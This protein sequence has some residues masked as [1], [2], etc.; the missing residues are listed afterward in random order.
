MKMN[1]LGWVSLCLGLLVSA[2]QA[3]EMP[4]VTVKSFTLTGEIQGENITFAMDMTVDAA[5]GGSR[6]TLASGSIA[7]LDGQLPGGVELKRDGASYEAVFERRG[8]LASLFGGGDE[9]RLTA[10]FAALAAESNDWRSTSFDVP[11]A[12]VRQ[13]VIVCDREDLAVQFPGAVQVDRRKN[14]AGKTE[15]VAYLTPGSM[16]AVHWKPQVRKLQGELAVTCD[17]CAVASASVGA[18]KLDTVFTYRVVQGQLERLSLAVPDQ[19]NVTQVSGEDIREWRLDPRPGGGRV[20]SVALSRPQAK[21]YVLRVEGER[22]LAA[23][24]CKF[25]LPVVVP[26]GVIRAGGFLLLGTDSAVRLI[27]AK[28]AGLSQIDPSA[29]PKSASPEAQR[30]IVPQ[31]AA[32]AYQYAHLPFQMEL[33]AEDIVTSLSSEER[34]T[35]SCEDNGL[36]LDAVVDVEIRDAPTRELVLETDP[37]WAVAQVQ[38]SNVSDYDVRDQA[39]KREI[40]VYFQDAAIGHVLV[41]VRLERTLGA[42]LATFTAPKLALRDAKAERG[43]LVLR[44]EKG[45]RLKEGKAAELREIHTA[46][47]PFRVPDAQRAY[48]FK[49]QDWTLQMA[50]EQANA[51]IYAELFHL[52]SLGEGSLYGSVSITYRVEGAPVRRFVVKAPA[53][54]QNIEFTGRDIRGWEREGELITVSLQEKVMGD[55]TLLLTFEQRFA[56]EGAEL[57]VGGVET[58]NA[59]SEVGYIALSGPASLAFET[60]KKRDPSMIAISGG[61]L[62]REYAL[63]VNEPV[64]RAYKYVRAPHAAQLA[65]RRYSTQSLLDHVADHISLRTRI[66]AEGEAVTEATYYV[67]NTSR[68]FLGVTL[69]SGAK[70]WSARVDGAP[71]QA[72]DDGKGAV[73]IPIKRLQ[74]ANTPSR[75]ELA[76]AEAR[77]K[78]RWFRG[79][80]F[81]APLCAAQSVF[82]R[83]TIAWPENFSLLPRG[84]NMMPPALPKTGLKTVVGRMLEIYGGIWSEAAG[85]MAAVVVLGALVVFVARRIGRGALVSWSSAVV[86][87]LGLGLCLVIRSFSDGGADD[88]LGAAVRTVGWHHGMAKETTF[89]KSV[90]MTARELQVGVRVV[91]PWLGGTGGLFRLALG[92]LIGLALALWSFAGGRKPLAFAAGMTLL[93]WAVTAIP[94]V[95]GLAALLLAACL[96]V[97]VLLALTRWAFATGRARRKI[98]PAAPSM[99]PPFMRPPATMPLAPSPVPAAGADSSRNGSIRIK[100]LIGL[101]AAG[102]LAVAGLKAE[103][104]L[105]QTEMGATVPSHVPAA[106]VLKDVAMKIAAPDPAKDREGIA[107]VEL[108]VDFKADGPCEFVAFP[109]DY[110]LIDSTLESR[111]GR[112]KPGKDGFA[113]EVSR[114]GAYTL[115]FKGYAPAS[116]KAGVWSIPLSLPASL[117]NKV[118]VTIPAGG[119]DV[120]CRS[121]AALEQSE[122]DKTVTCS[123]SL[124]TTGSARI[125]WRPRERATRLEQPV[126]YCDLQTYAALTPGLAS[127]T[128]VARYQVAQG[129]IQT[130][131]FRIPDGMSVT[132]VTGAGLGTWRY[133]PETRLLEALM[134]KPAS[135]DFTLV[136]TTQIPREGLP[137]TA[138]IGAIA[139]EGAARQR[140]SIAL[141]AAGPVQ[142]RV[143]TVT[144]LSPMNIGDF[145]AEAVQ[146]AMTGARY[147]EPPELKRAYRYHE[148]PAVV[149]VNADRVV[150]EIRVTEQASLDITDER[151]VLTSRL[152]M[153]VTRAGVFDLRLDLPD[154]FDIESLTGQDIS[155]WDEVKEG[156]RGVIVHFKKQAL[157]KRTV[158]IVMGRMEKGI[159]A[160]IR[161]PRIGVR[162]AVKHVGTLAVSGERGVRFLTAEK[163]GVSEV[164][165]RELGIEQ[166]G[167]LAFRLLR[168]DW[169]IALKTE[170]LAPVVR[171][172]SLLRVDVS[173][174]MIRGHCKL[175]YKIDQAGVKTFR[176]KAPAPGVP[177]AISGRNVAKV[178]ETDKAAG[179][180]EVE[181]QGKVENR[182]SLDVDYQQPCEPTAKTLRILP[183]QTVGT[184]AQKGYVVVFT[185]GRLQVRVE[186]APE[187]LHAKDARSV[188]ATFGAGDLSDA[189]L[190]YQTSQPDFGLDLSVVR[191][192]EAE[193]LPARV[194][195]L[196]LTSVVS[197]DGQM[198]T[199]MDMKVNVGTLRFL[200]VTLPAG[201]EVWSVFVNDT[202]SVPLKDRGKVMVPL[203]SARV[204]GD[205]S[206][207]LT[208]VG[209][210]GPGGAFGR[211]RIEGP[212]FNIPLAD[213]QWNIY[214]PPNYR[215]HGFGGTLTYQE[216]G[217]KDG[218]AVF[219]EDQYR[220]FNASAL[221]ASN[222]K[223]EEVLRAGET[224]WKAGKQEQAKQALKQAV[225][226]SQG[227]Q[228]LN[229]DARIQ[230]RNVT[231][232]QAV[233]GFYNRRGA[234]KRSQNVIEEGDRQQVAA[235]P[236]Q[237]ADSGQWTADY[238][239]QI[240]QSLGADEAGNLNKVADK[241][242]EQQAAAQMRTAPI[243]V[244]LPM[245]GVHLPFHRDL[246]INTAAEMNVEFKAGSGW[247]LGL[248][249]SAGATVLLLAMFWASMRSLGR[250]GQEGG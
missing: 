66:S 150:P 220:Q 159:E 176:L 110:V 27:V 177:L 124:V 204:T 196:V 198:V 7:Y 112:I 154:A 244:T 14:A 64:L 156:G 78:L 121:A 237:Q 203:E 211:E 239:R 91:P 190:C 216:P 22:V 137:Y 54:C 146:S 229:E 40:R 20:L 241:M 69:P 206:V 231:R 56:D 113:V 149:A 53:A 63:L 61:E 122:K 84:G 19:L 24:P 95:V 151:L 218:V 30:Q 83:W 2:A 250:P 23:F 131:R 192:A 130:L 183:V 242:L 128:H 32:S 77:P 33:S 58:L 230:Y 114:A 167:Y 85:W 195:S 182:Y 103:E 219:G 163:D 43:Y 45:I 249:G 214:V 104:S 180:W 90:T 47:V 162:D 233:V 39:G 31:R 72:L 166:P 217:R 141:A 106:I 67:K 46:S 28:A 116:Q 74:D 100:G 9:Q 102:L 178:T 188:P 50:I 81:D 165:P 96:P 153:I 11:C 6:L 21:Q 197:D 115:T 222:A 80:S 129:E 134:E 245:Q 187:T 238:G 93:L 139:V 10:R 172:E 118:T 145:P 4:G 38:G 89:T 5:R 212:R 179:L 138:V 73:L 92:G 213:L 34:L 99:P 143:D 68:Q 17:G 247:L 223:A 15:V 201:A 243:R 224:L 234:L 140:G 88:A 235:Q 8:W 226:L 60:E 48:R 13:V 221:E 51:A 164:H 3:D 117:K 126:F 170:A 185:S 55:Y 184:D 71:V 210:A 135:G 171:A 98:E 49:N 193:V 169:S 225:I 174:G 123:M 62:P 35:L 65:G 175:Q 18:L 133:E 125:S 215:Y 189:I 94:P 209:L 127:M 152:E 168:P 200:D 44:A 36:T 82:A 76:Y 1:R 205:A 105:I 232:Q 26:E 181:L 144:G 41:N 59:A 136:V 120:A 132:A 108:T 57:A 228:G 173:E 191:H 207:E 42:G 12:V 148:L 155:H 208:Y 160:Q 75:V 37:A 16:F 227:Q 161:V 186:K 52:I 147:P 70:L 86:V 240:E 236:G 142:V 158:N 87:L 25:D 248:M 194:R 79:L 29:F 202:A 246:Q 199:R 119:W 97:A 157:G 111:D 109:P 107:N 101:L